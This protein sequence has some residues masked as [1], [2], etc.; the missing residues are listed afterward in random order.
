MTRAVLAA[1]YTSAKSAHALALFVIAV[2]GAC[3]LRALLW[4]LGWR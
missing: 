2:A 4:L 1:G 3:G